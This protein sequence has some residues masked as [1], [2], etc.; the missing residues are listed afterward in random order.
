VIA[1][2]RKRFALH[3]NGS[4]PLP[5]MMRGFVFNL[6]RTTSMPPSQRLDSL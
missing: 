3:A 6:V 5:D 2:A 1:E 4:T